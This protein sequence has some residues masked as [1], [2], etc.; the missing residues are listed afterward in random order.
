MFFAKGEINMNSIYKVIWSKA[1]NCYVVASEIAKSH[2]KSASGQSVRRSALASLLALSLLCGGL[3]VAEAS[4][5]VNVVGGGTTEVYRTSETY[6]KTETDGKLALKADA[7]D[8]DTNT[9]NINN[10]DGKL[11]NLTTTVNGKADK[12][13]VDTE[14]TKKADVTALGEYA[15]TADV[16]TELA[17]KADATALGEYAKT[18]DVNTE[19]AKKADKAT[20]LAGYGITDAYNKGEVYN[21]G[22]VAAKLNT[23]AN[24]KDLTQA[25]DRITANEAAITG[26]TTKTTE[27]SYVA[28]DGTKIS[29]VTIK[30]GNIVGN[31]N[32]AITGLTNVET[33]N[34]NG[35]SL[36]GTTVATAKDVEDA[37][38]AETDARTVADTALEG[39]IN[40]EKTA[41]EAKDN[42][43]LGRIGKVAEDG[44]Y[45]KKSDTNSVS[46]N[47]KALDAQAKINADAIAAETVARAAKDTELE[48]KI[49]KNSQDITNL[50]G[51]VTT[52]Q[53]DITNLTAKD[54]E[55]EGKIQTNANNI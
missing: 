46:K 52:A 18:A 17:K 44:N 32:S 22:E 19:L 41:R 13:Y 54:T 26:L 53:G 35:K 20:T 43:I 12:T 3:G 15:K 2:T 47:L 1:K 16:N 37:V 45:I 55:L 49:T 50:Q 9:A 24:Q 29:G 23:K 31:G 14:L 30:D 4:V 28:G 11:A 6:T 27:I 51:D 39:K 25:T 34:I 7:I 48:G 21:R 33:G 38:K 42:A 5:R 36:V 40:D 8:V 10:L